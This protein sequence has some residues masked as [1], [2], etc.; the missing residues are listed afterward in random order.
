MVRQCTFWVPRGS[1]L[2]LGR[3]EDQESPGDM[4]AADN[5]CVFLKVPFVALQ[6]PT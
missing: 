5:S 4:S 6:G 2:C 3:D 1:E